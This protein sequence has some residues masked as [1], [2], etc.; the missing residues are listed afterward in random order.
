MINR[1]RLLITYLFYIIILIWFILF[2][3]NIKEFCGKY[4]GISLIPF[5]DKYNYTSYFARYACE[6]GN[7]ISFIPSGIYLTLFFKEEKFLNRFLKSI[8]YIF[9][10]SLFLE[11]VQYFLVIGISSTTDLLHNSLGGLIGVSLYET[12]K[13][14][15][16]TKRIDDI[17]KYTLFIIIPLSIFAVIN[18]LIHINLYI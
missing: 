16:S 7:V 8:C 3:L 14:F 1:K 4:N 10:L 15:V 17:N 11:I 6:I 5:A 13:K 18:T 9:C 12:L 2:R